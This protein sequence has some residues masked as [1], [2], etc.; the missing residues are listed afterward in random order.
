MKTAAV[1]SETDKRSAGILKTTTRSTDNNVVAFDQ[2]L[3]SESSL[4]WLGLDQPD[5]VEQQYIIEVDDRLLKINTTST[6]GKD[7]ASPS[8]VD[9]DSIASYYFSLS[10]TPG[11]FAAQE[12][13]PNVSNPGNSGTNI[14]SVAFQVG[15]GGVNTMTIKSIGTSSTTGLF[16][17]RLV[18]GITTSSDLRNQAVTEGLW[19][20]LGKTENMN[21]GDGVDA[22]YQVINTVLRVTGVNTGYRTDISVAAIK[23]V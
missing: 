16:G 3:D 22:D 7:L 20:K 9:D 15:D 17:T 14:D 10:N 12:G 18:F 1:S 11:Y 23:K 19:S 4:N 5:L 2:G 6:P 8:F 21:F 13:G